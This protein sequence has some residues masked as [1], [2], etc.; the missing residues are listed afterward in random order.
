MPTG[1]QQN[2]VAIQE[3]T[4]KLTTPNPVSKSELFGAT[5]MLGLF[6]FVTIDPSTDSNDA[7][8]ATEPPQ[9]FKSDEPL[10]RQA[11]PALWKLL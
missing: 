6:L 1:Y 7:S 3:A 11:A 9:T 5:I 8:L 10:L 4:N 2:I